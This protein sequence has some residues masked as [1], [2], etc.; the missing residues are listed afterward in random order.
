MKIDGPKDPS[1]KEEGGCKESVT[2]AGHVS[3][4]KDP[5]G[6]TEPFKFRASIFIIV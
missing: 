2:R 4:S 5:R 1:F 3:W 6:L